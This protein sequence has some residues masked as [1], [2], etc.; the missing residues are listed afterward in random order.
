MCNSRSVEGL[1]GRPW[2]QMGIV[3]FYHLMFRGHFAGNYH[4]KIGL[5]EEINWCEIFPGLLT[6]VFNSTTVH[7]AFW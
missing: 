2:I 3:K 1:C 7:T 6:V 5:L 4:I